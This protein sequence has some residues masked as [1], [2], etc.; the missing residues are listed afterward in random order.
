[1]KKILNRLNFK[2][3]DLII[4]PAAMPAFDFYNRTKLLFR[5]GF[6]KEIFNKSLFESDLIFNVTSS[7]KQIKII[8]GFD[9]PYFDIEK[10]DLSNHTIISFD[11][12]L[13]DIEIECFSWKSLLTNILKS[14]IDSKS[15]SE[16]R[17]LSNSYIPKNVLSDVLGKKCLTQEDIAIITSRSRTTIAKQDQKIKTNNDF[18]VR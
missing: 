10:I 15:L 9:F 6:N 7:N 4:H 18:L 17:T 11:E 3:I 1:M 14:S 5:S 16:L 8:T 13:S 12:S 2:N